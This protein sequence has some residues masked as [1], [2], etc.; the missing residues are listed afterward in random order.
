MCDTPEVL[1]LR[2]PSLTLVDLRPNLQVRSK[3]S[4]CEPS[5]RLCPRYLILHLAPFDKP[6]LDISTVDAPIL[7][8]PGPPVTLHN[9]ITLA[10]PSRPVPPCH[11]PPTF[12]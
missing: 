6:P 4:T 1:C 10:P 11:H 2:M 12:S 9:V 5:C 8:H 3:D 7:R